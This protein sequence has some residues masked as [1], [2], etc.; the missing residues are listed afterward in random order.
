MSLIP[1]P[2]LTDNV[3]FGGI[4]SLSES[5]YVRVRLCICLRARLLGPREGLTSTTTEIRGSTSGGTP[6]NDAAGDSETGRRAQWYG[7]GSC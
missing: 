1:E 7:L 3:P 6:A 2:A 5:V 4:A